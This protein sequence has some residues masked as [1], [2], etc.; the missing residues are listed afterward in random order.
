MHDSVS[1]LDDRYYEDVKE[2]ASVLSERSLFFHRLL[3]EALYLEALCREGILRR[4]CGGFSSEEFMKRLDANWYEQIKDIEKAVR[5]D[6]KATE[7]YMRKRLMELGYT[8]LA[9][10]VH[11][12]LTSEDVNANAYGM[13]LEKGKRK[14][15]YCYLDLTL[16]LSELSKRYASSI[17]MGRTHGVPAEPTTFG[18]EISYFA[19][20]LAEAAERLLRI[21]PYGKLSGAVGTY[22]SFMFVDPSVDW[23][24]FSKRFIERLGLEFPEVSKQAPLWDNAARI[25]QEIDLINYIMRELAQDL[26]L[27]NSLGIIQFRRAGV[28]SS[29]MPHKVNPV[30]LED[31]EG[32]LEISSSVLQT[33][34]HEP[35]YTRMQRDLSDS[36]VRRNLGAALA[37]SYLGCRRILKALEQL[38]FKGED[39]NSHREVLSEPLQIAFKLSGDLNAYEK[40]FENIENMDKLVEE[41]PEPLKGAFSSLR[42]SDYVGLSERLAVSVAELAERKAREI[43]KEVE[44]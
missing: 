5:H 15:L 8:G 30:D 6:V 7:L 11:L 17:M 21:R 24:L 31:A 3:V 23:L 44:Q 19:Y 1:P 10:L 16:R 35:L 12:A 40:V 32:Q 36:P 38:V 14:V 13:M 42:P 39:V 28:G 4:P 29:T 2:I 18:K 37:H 34:I 25:L 22:S 41:L 9:P 33:T 20:R 26:W 43:L 27:Y